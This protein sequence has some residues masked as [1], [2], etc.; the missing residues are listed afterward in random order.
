MSVETTAAAAGEIGALRFDPM[1]MLPFCGYNMADYFG[2]W[3]KTGRRE[4]AQL[5]KVFL[6]N[7]FRKN[8]DG[9]FV[10]PGFGDNIRVLEWVFRRCD[11]DGEAVETP[12]G[13]VPAEGEIDTEGTGVSDEDMKL[14]LGVDPDAVKA[15]LPQVHEHL[16]RFG[17]Q[18]PKEIRAQLEALEKRLG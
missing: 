11:G 9:E 12:I 8:D 17:D 14:L 6:V 3:L 4:G 2:H 1:A 18:L 5:P 7:W 10:W 13:L 16:A 15:Q